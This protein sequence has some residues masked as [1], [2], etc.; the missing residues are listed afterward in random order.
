MRCGKR[1]SQYNTTAIHSTQMGICFR[2]CD[3]HVETETDIEMQRDLCFSPNNTTYTNKVG[4]R[5]DEILVS[6]SVFLLLHTDWERDASRVICLSYS[7][8]IHW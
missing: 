8:I 2:A 5:C 4:V 7:A 1:L 3:I 6:V